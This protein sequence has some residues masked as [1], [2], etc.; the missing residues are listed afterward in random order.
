MKK[1]LVLMLLTSLSGFSQQL[2]HTGARVYDSN[3]QKLQP[4]AVRELMK[5]NQKALASYNAGRDKLTWGNVLLYGG[6][7]LATFNLVQAVTMNTIETDRYG[8]ITT[9]KTGP[10]LAIVGGVMVLAAIPIK[11]GFSKKIQTA[12]DDYNQKV[13]CNEKVKS[14]ISIVADNNGLGFRISF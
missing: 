6:L 13:V 10:E 3:N 2:T 12:V 9:K 1:F 7:S 4:E 11:I 5:N 8:N 14:D